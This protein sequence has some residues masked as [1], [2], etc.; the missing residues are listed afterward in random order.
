VEKVSVVSGNT[1]LASGATA[2][3]KKWKFTPFTAEGKP[4]KALA[5]L[6]F[7]FNLNTN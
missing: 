4:C 5:R 7:D 6:K 2:A 1:V 3:L